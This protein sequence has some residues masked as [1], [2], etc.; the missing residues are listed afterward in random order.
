MMEIMPIK[1]VSLVASYPTKK[2][3]TANQ[4]APLKIFGKNC[5]FVLFVGG[6]EQCWEPIQIL[7]PSEY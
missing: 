1:G 3:C 2:Y 7:L 6:E 5:N 4:F